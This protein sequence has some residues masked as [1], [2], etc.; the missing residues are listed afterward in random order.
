MNFRFDR[1][2]CIVI[3]LFNLS[4]VKI[5]YIEGKLMLNVFKVLKNIFLVFMMYYKEIVKGFLVFE[6]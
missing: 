5:I 6:F 1:V 2:I 4:V 3:V